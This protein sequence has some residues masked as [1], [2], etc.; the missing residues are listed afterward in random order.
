M[1]KVCRNKEESPL[2]TRRF[3]NYFGILERGT[4][5]PY[6]AQV[7]FLVIYLFKLFVK[8]QCV[9]FSVVCNMLAT[10]WGC[11]AGS[12]SIVYEFS[13]KVQTRTPR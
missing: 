9:H 8:E 7:L 5:E 11:D 12:M 13:V 3:Q 10:A 2:V 4:F 6:M 1:C